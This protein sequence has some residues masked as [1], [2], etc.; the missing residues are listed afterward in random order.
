M[1]HR[2]P[3]SFGARRHRRRRRELEIVRLDAL[4]ER[5]DV[6]RLPFS[7]KALLEK[8]CTTRTAKGSRTRRSRRWDPGGP[9]STEI[10]LF[11]SRVFT[12]DFTGVSAIVDLAACGTRSRRWV[13]THS[14]SPLCRSSW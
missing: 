6:A 14:C 2:H 11:P 12:H 9:A 5:F 3:D 1:D 8:L 7:L 10:A 13:A 4:Q